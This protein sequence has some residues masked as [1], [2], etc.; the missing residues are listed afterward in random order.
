MKRVGEMRH[1][2]VNEKRPASGGPGVL[3]SA[4]CAGQNLH[5]FDPDDDQWEGKCTSEQHKESGSRIHLRK[6]ESQRN[7]D[8]RVAMNEEGG[9]QMGHAEPQQAVVQVVAVGC[10]RRLT[11]Q[12]PKR[13]NPEGIDQRVA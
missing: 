2:L 3:L 7:H 10:E 6:A 12:Y 11:F 13:E 4:Q 1:L 9:L 5:L 8:G